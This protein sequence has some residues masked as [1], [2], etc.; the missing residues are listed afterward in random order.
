[1]PNK[2]FL[3][4]F[5]LYRKF[6]ID[7]PLLTDQVEKVTIKM[8]CPTCKSD[9]TF[10]MVNEY[11]ERF[12]HVNYPLQAID[13]RLDYACAHCQEFHRIF[14]IKID[15]KRQSIIKIGQYPA[16]DIESD[17]YI[18]SLLGKKAELYKK[19][20]ICESQ[21]YGIAAFAYYRRI[22]EEVIDSL[23][24]EI[25]DLIEGEEKEKYLAA[26]KQTKETPIAANKIALVKDL[27]PPILR[28]EGMNPLN[29]LY[30]ILSGGLHTQS[31]DECLDIAM[32]IREV[33][34]YMV[35]QV[36]STRQASKSFTASMRSLLEKKKK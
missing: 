20:L 11:W 12:D 1:M 7:L 32:Q 4:K 19:G 16:W 3:E 33:L 5:P 26:L 34:S 29:T 28:P 10:L 14:F 23:L 24:E 21:G 13:L 18:D 2:E 31:E 8:W 6:D 35:S 17:E 27:L 15:A 30:S 22:V 9:Q 36:A 25:K